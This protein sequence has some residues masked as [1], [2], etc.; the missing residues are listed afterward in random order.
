MLTIFL[1]SIKKGIMKLDIQKFM[2]LNEFLPGPISNHFQKGKMMKLAKSLM[3][4]LIAATFA[5]AGCMQQESTEMGSST[6]VE[7][8]SNLDPSEGDEQD[9]LLEVNLGGAS[10]AERFMGS[11]DEITRISLD[12]VRD[13]GNKLVVDDFALT[14]SDGKWIGTV[15]KL[16]VGFSYTITGH[17]YRAFNPTTDSW[18]TAFPDKDG[19]EWLELFIGEVNHPVVEGVNTLDLRLAPILDH[20][21]LSVPRITR[22]QRPFQ[23]PTNEAGDVEVSVD[24]VGTGDNRTLGYR[25]RPVDTSGLPVTDGTRGS[26]SP[27]EGDVDHDGSGI[28]PIIST[29]YTAPA[30]DSPCFTDDVNGQCAQKLQIRVSN[31]Q[32]IGV[33]AHF[34]VYATDDE[35]AESTVDTLPVISSIS[36]ERVG[37]NELQWTID[38]S[39][40]DLFS[41]L[42]VN[43]DYMFGEI[44]LFSEFRND[45]M[46]AL[47][48]GRMQALMEYEDTDEG[49]L[50]VTVCDNDTT[51]PENCAYQSA[52][53]TSVEYSLIAHAYPE[54]V[55]CDDTGC[56][57]PNR[58]AGRMDTPKTWSNCTSSSQGDWKQTWELTSKTFSK[59]REQFSS[60]GETCDPSSLLYS[61][62]ITGR[63]EQ[64]SNTAF[65]Y[66]T[67]SVQ[68]TYTSENV[69]VFKVIFTVN[70]NEMTLHNADNVTSF[71][72]SQTCGYS[73]NDWAVGR[74]LDVSGCSD[75]GIS[76]A[77]TQDDS[78]TTIIHHS[79][80]E[81]NGP[82][83]R[84]GSGLSETNLDCLE[85]GLEGTSTGSSSLCSGGS[86]T[87]TSHTYRLVD[88][89]GS[90]EDYGFTSVTE[91]EC[92][93]SIGNFESPWDTQP[94]TFE[95][96]PTMGGYPS[97]LL[98]GSKIYF[99]SG[100]DNNSCGQAPCVCKN[101]N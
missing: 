2:Y 10:R 64:D 61:Q 28:Y 83:I 42:S 62:T 94:W 82:R 15:P 32:E 74:T 25:F 5:I 7:Q 51:T 4:I 79:D 67:T 93:Q 66:P 38:V 22:I 47:H 100:G 17:A 39:D 91:N 12:I 86:T 37:P 46:G 49:L 35:D 34:T 81:T 97:C 8:V 65:V 75:A 78:I 68:D 52:G 44:R 16:I 1:T 56:E 14:Q 92:E 9:T 58:L 23:L 13:Y 29:D 45:S 72:S 70:T 40:D 11:Y 53:S 76:Y 89:T 77:Y 24:T 80:N 43:W 19:N 71:N 18:A 33:S 20:R 85:L 95:V 99:N 3:T 69:D 57:L 73:A 6:E 96:G 55:I 50:L 21:T 41:E 101:S 90:C 36:A 54:I 27:A 48:S 30:E 60:S 88:Q 98:S 59:T 87:S 84:L 31:L 26:F 63:A